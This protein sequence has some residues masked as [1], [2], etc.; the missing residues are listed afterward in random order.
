[1]NA[2]RRAS[3][4]DIETLIEHVRRVVADKTGVLLETEVR[5]IGDPL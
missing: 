2:E 5:I 3:A 4:R 1:V